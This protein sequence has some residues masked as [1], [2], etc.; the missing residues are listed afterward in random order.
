M[1]ETGGGLG[2]SFEQACGL[3]VAIGIPRETR[4]GALGF[5]G[6]HQPEESERADRGCE[7]GQ[8]RAQSSGGLLRLRAKRVVELERRRRVDPV[9]QGEPRSRDHACDPGDEGRHVTHHA[10]ERFGKLP[11]ELARCAPRA[12]QQRFV[13][14]RNRAARIGRNEPRKRLSRARAFALAFAPQRKA[15]EPA[16]R[17]LEVHAHER[18]TSC[19]FGFLEAM[20]LH[21]RGVPGLELGLAWALC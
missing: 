14:P 18:K 6:L 3:G 5:T 11:R 21:G 20:R 13:D 15:L 16:E 4:E 9:P 7:H 1:W 17:G 2:L 12:N 19:L 8:T 10:R